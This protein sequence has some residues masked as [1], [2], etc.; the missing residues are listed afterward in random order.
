MKLWLAIGGWDYEGENA[1]SAR[2]FATK[3]LAEEYA[4]KLKVKDEWGTR[5]HYSIVKELEAPQ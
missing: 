4:E 2:L 5:Y 1:D 3:E